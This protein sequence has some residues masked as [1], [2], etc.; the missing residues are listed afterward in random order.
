MVNTLS[1]VAEMVRIIFI[2][3]V[4]PHFGILKMELG[5]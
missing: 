5:V 2:E 4:V 1:L 3:T